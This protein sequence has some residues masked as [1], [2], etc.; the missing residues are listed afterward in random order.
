MEQRYRYVAVAILLE[1]RR[2]DG[3]AVDFRV[4][5]EACTLL[6]DT[7]ELLRRSVQAKI[8]SVSSSVASLALDKDNLQPA[9]RRTT[10]A[11]RWPEVRGR[12]CRAPVLGADGLRLRGADGPFLTCANCAWSRRASVTSGRSSPSSQSFAAFTF[13]LAASRDGWFL[14]TARAHQLSDHGP[15]PWTL[16][17]PLRRPSARSTGQS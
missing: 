16:G 12:L 10:S 1:Q 8:A 15:A 17:R 11:A 3:V 2:H 4:P 5:E 9:R 7:D 13:A 6:Q 14:S